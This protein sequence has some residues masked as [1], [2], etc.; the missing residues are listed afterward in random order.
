MHESPLLYMTSVNKY[1]NIHLSKVKHVRV[2]HL[3]QGHKI[4][5]IL[6]LEKHYIYLKILHQT[7]FETFQIIPL[8]NN[9]NHKQSLF[10]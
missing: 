3:A 2:I 1:I 6:K 10:R 9:I 8:F 4:V 7:E 5:P